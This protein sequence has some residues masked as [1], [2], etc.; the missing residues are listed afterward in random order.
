[1]D[2]PELRGFK[3]RLRR[4]GK[5]L[6]TVKAPVTQFKALLAVA[7]P[8]DPET[9][10]GSD[11]REKANCEV[12]APGPDLSLNDYVSEIGTNN[13]WQVVYREDNPADFTTKYVLA[14][15]TNKDQ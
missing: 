14:K 5:R 11:P 7:P 15:V 12:L 8:F 9:E 10:L 4:D 1:M 13:K 2:S 3:D 6:K